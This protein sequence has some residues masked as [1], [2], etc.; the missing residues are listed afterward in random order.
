LY[1]SYGNRRDRSHSNTRG[2]SYGDRDDQNGSQN[3]SDGNRRDQSYSNTRENTRD[4]FYGDRDNQ[5]DA[6]SR[7][8]HS[9]SDAQRYGRDTRDR[10][11][12][13]VIVRQQSDESDRTQAFEGARRRPE[14]FWGGGFF[15]RGGGYQD[16]D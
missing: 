15:G 5:N 12:S 4:P 13:R 11:R 6:A 8:D 10:G 7:S 3:A 2:Q 14:P 1:D 9:R 16:D